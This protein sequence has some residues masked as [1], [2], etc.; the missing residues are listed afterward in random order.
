MVENPDANE[1]YSLALFDCQS[2]KR[3]FSVQLIHTNA[4]YFVREGNH[5]ISVARALGQTA[6]EAEVI[7]YKKS[8]SLLI[9]GRFWL[10]LHGRRYLRLGFKVAYSAAVLW[11]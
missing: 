7:S 8:S 11:V 6:I 2:E 5:R 1:D 3:P 4:G 9:D 10:L